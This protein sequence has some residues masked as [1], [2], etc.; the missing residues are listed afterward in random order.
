MTYGSITVTGYNDSPPSDDGSA[1]EANR[2]YWSTIKTKLFDPLKTA[3]EALNSAIDTEIAL[4]DSTFF[5]EG[6]TMLF[7]QSAAPTGWSKSLDTDHN[8][9]TLRAITGTTGGT[10]AGNNLFSTTLADRTFSVTQANLP[11]LDFSHSLVAASHMHSAGSL[12]KPS[13]YSSTGSANI[14]TAGG[15][16][17]MLRNKNQG[18]DQTTA[19]YCPAQWLTLNSTT[20]ALDENLAVTGTVASGGGD[21]AVSLDFRVKYVDL[22][23]ASM[24]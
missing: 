24:N 15:G 16:I 7:A 9:V 6:T 11:S 18:Q 4:I 13:T 22:I 5:N 12:V 10:V 20:G 3:A 17:T 21:T 23:V 14:T 19:I 2:A 8:D 1:T